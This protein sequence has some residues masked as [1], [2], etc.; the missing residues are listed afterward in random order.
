V[1]AQLRAGFIFDKAGGCSPL[2]VR[3]TNQTSGASASASYLWDFGNGNPLRFVMHR[4]CI[5]MRA[6]Y[7]D[8]DGYYGGNVS[9]VSHTVTVYPHSKPSFLIRLI[10]VCGP[11]RSRCGCVAE[12]VAAADRKGSGPGYVVNWCGIL[13][14]GRRGRPAAR[15]LSMFIKTTFKGPASLTVTN[16]LGCVDY[17]VQRWL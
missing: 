4:L 13:G 9:T 12:Y 17:G 1:S 5:L 14:M 16:K 10:R 3:F 2:I 11:Q 7:G 15:L 6:L 8:A